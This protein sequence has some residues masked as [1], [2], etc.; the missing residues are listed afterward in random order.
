MS[1]W[2]RPSSIGDEMLD[3]A[4]MLGR[5]EDVEPALLAGRGERGLALE[6]EMLLPAD[7]ERAGQAVR[8]GGERGIGVAARHDLRRLDLGAGRRARRRW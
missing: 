6:I 4:R 8:R 5:A 7:L 3:L 2:L 1:A